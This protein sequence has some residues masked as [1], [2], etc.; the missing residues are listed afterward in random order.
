MC[1]P[2][3]RVFSIACMV[4]IVA[5]AVTLLYTLC[6]CVS[7]FFFAQLHV[8]S[9]AKLAGIL[10]HT[11]CNGCGRFLSLL[12]CIVISRSFFLNAFAIK[13]N[14]EN[15]DTFTYKMHATVFE[16]MKMK[17]RMN[18]EAKRTHIHTTVRE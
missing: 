1:E 15:V 2:E 5:T 12:F 18:R 16:H 9:L 11:E 6:V 14:I 3:L 4:D 7:V 13:A 17:T 8:L 10:F